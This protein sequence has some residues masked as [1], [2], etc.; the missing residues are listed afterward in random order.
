MDKLPR[1]LNP[2]PPFQAPALPLARL[3]LHTDL[4]LAVDIHAS[5]MHSLTQP[6]IIEIL[7]IC[8]E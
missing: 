6:Y 2:V 1:Y 3:I 8:Y 4:K 7:H 5:A